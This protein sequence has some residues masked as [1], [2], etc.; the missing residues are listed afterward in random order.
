MPSQILLLHFSDLRRTFILHAIISVM[1]IHFIYNS[2]T[3]SGRL[4]LVPE[5]LPT[6]WWWALQIPAP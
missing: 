4:S 5:D 1:K 3:Y 2:P 6:H